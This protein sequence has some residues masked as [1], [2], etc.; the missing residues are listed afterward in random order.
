MM[1]FFYK[2]ATFLQNQFTQKMICD[3]ISQ[4][5]FKIFLA[6]QRTFKGNCDDM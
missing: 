3:L 1:F 6:N 2:I 4:S 5:I